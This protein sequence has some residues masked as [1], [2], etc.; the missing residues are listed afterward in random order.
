M[1]KKTQLVTVA[2]ISGGLLIGASGT[3]MAVGNDSKPATASP[4][5]TTHARPTKTA[6]PAPSTTTDGPRT[7]PAQTAQPTKRAH[8]TTTAKPRTARPT[9]TAEPTPATKVAE[10]TAVPRARPAK[11][12][13]GAPKFTG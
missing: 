2:L 1:R 3:A 6:E 13:Q 11:P 10:P 8:A 4:T 9:K 12:V 7:K 5:V